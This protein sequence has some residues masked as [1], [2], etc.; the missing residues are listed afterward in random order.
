M[1][2]L[3]ATSHRGLW[4]GVERYL[5][6][7]IPGLMQRGHSLGLLYEYPLDSKERALDSQ[8]A[9]VPCWCAREMGLESTMRSIHSW[10]PELVYCHGLDDPSLEGS[11]LKSLPVALYAH[12]YFGTCVSSRKCFSWPRLEPC[13]R[14]LGASCLLHYFPRRC[15]GLDP[16][17]MWRLYQIQSQRKSRFSQYRAVLVA[18]RAMYEEYQRHGVPQNRLHLVP[19]PIEDG[20]ACPALPR[21]EI[22]DYRI[23]FVGRLMDVK[24]VSHLLYALPLAAKALGRALNLTI[25]GDGPDRAKLE[26]LARHLDLKVEF[27]GWIDSQERALRMRQAEL[28]AVPS[29]WPEPFGMVGVEAGRYGVP[30]VGFAVGGIPDW[31]VPGET[32]ELAPGDPPTREGLAAAITRA[33][34]QPDHYQKL[35]SGAW[36]MAQ[37][38]S[39][40]RHLADLENVLGPAATAHRS[41]ELM[42]QALVT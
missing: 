41:A 18:S 4:G 7:V 8:A 9:G 6:S 42:A 24:G 29:L 22:R 17:T 31:L 5:Q 36:E 32:G 33:F 26:E 34:A 13:G 14:R 1:R 10:A 40:G 20:L 11:L 12:S 35:S 2:I 27:T 3:I 21:K 39:L 25:A 37:R 28:L 23:L 30:A 15:G 19:L 16:A 38:F